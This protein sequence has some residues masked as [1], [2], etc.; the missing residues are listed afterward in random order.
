VAR[1][2]RR[3]IGGIDEACVDR[4][5]VDTTSAGTVSGDGRNGGQ[6]APAGVRM[7]IAPRRAAPP[8]IFA[9]RFRE[10]VRDCGLGTRVEIRLTSVEM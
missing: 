6:A 10:N 1:R 7:A 3:E 5:T 4:S 2:R 9:R 8:A